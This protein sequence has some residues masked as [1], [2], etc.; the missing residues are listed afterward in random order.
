MRM[1]EHDSPMLIYQRMQYSWANSNINIDE[2]LLNMNEAR[3]FMLAFK[4]EQKWDVS[5]DEPN[6]IPRMK[7]FWHWSNSCVNL[8]YRH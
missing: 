5:A 6:Q 3:G 8:M 4:S 1:T 7:H 2:A